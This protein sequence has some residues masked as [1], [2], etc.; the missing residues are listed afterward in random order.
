MCCTRRANNNYSIQLYN[1]MPDFVSANYLTQLTR[2]LDDDLPEIDS[3]SFPPMS[4][5]LFTT[6]GIEKLL[7]II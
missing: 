2:E 3:D 1:T 7:I 4:D 6:P 5:I